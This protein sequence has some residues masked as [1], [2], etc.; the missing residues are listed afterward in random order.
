MNTKVLALTRRLSQ[1]PR[2]VPGGRAGCPEEAA[3]RNVRSCD[4]KINRQLLEHTHA[5]EA[6]HTNV[7]PLRTRVRIGIPVEEVPT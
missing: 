6:D 5:R 7:R 2:S 1:S 3:R 4:I